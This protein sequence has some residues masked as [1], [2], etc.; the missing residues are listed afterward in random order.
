LGQ[1]RCQNREKRNGALGPK[2]HLPAF[3]LVVACRRRRS[4]L[5]ADL[6]ALPPTIS[7]G[8][9]FRGPCR[10]PGPKSVLEPT[11]SLP[12][13]ASEKR[14]VVLVGQLLDEVRRVGRCVVGSLVTCLNQRAAATATA[15]AAQGMSGAVGGREARQTVTDR[16][17]YG[18]ILSD[19]LALAVRAE[20]RIRRLMLRDSARRGFSFRVYGTPPS[21]I[22]HQSA[23]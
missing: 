3:G 1:Y 8:L 14:R 20:Q 9:F 5:S 17:Q 7:S 16:G 19:Q 21:A 11:P 13:A 2:V 12:L 23:P 6:A 15:V 10:G 22:E 4:D 18:L